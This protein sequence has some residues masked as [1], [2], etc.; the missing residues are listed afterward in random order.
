MNEMTA[1]ELGVLESTLPVVQAARHVRLDDAAIVAFAEKLSRETFQPPAWRVE[2]HWWDETERTAQYVFILD[3]LNFC[4]WGEPKW[5]VEYGGRIFDGY[6]ALAA[7]LRRAMENGLPLLEA[8][9]LAQINLEQV[10]GLVAGEGELALLPERAASLRQLGQT[11]QERHGG[12]AA[13]LVAQAG[14]SAVA[15]VRRVVDE[16]PLFDDVAEY[17]GRPVRFYKRAQILCSDLHGA[18]SGAGLGFLHDLHQLTAFADYKVP[19][20]L[21]E[22]GVL[23]YEADLAARV[24]ALV[25]LAPGCP[26]EIE[27]RAATIWAVEHLRQALADRGI[28]LRAF[29][30]DWALWQLGQQIHIP[31][32]YH[33]TRTTFY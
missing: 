20:V 7:A 14:G 15:L 30:I 13:N 26:E 19:Q 16:L 5:R 11:L 29:E 4:F 6:W 8:D 23:V 17:D 3:T 22:A 10:R 31:R 18:F 24:D 27:I 28:Q 2:P 25:E 32:P 12:Q 21:R 9:Y 1:S 33:R